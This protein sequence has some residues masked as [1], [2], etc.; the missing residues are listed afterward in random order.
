[1]TLMQLEIQIIAILVSLACVIPGIFLVLKKQAMMSD[2]I[3]HSILLGI[4]IAFIFTKDLLSPFLV[5]GAAL[6][7]LLVVF[8]VQI[9]KK[10]GLLKEDTSIGLVFPLFFS[11][12]VVIISLKFAN[13]HLDVDAVLLGEIAFAPL[14]RMKIFGI[15]IGAKSIYTTGLNLII[16]ITFLLVFFKELKI[17]TFDPGLSY[18]L[19]FS[20]VLLNYL[21]MGDVSFTAVASFDAVG[22]VLVVALMIA[23][24]ATAYLITDDL[25]K[26]ILWSFVFGTAIAL[27]G[28]WIAR[29]LD[30][31]IAGTMAAV[32]GLLFIEVF[33]QAPKKG[34]IS[35]IKNRKKLKLKFYATMMIVHISHHLGSQEYNEECAAGKIFSHLGW[36]KAYTTKI[37]KILIQNNY[38]EKKDDIL[39]LTEKGRNFAEISMIDG[40]IDRQVLNNEI[41]TV[42]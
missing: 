21:L 22:S 12:A 5:V 32:A 27:S 24:P 36:E 35:K 6:S 7:G 29:I 34:L 33:I 25:G 8:L 4:V 37:I 14:D 30:V 15:D 1:M 16:N 41:I 11:I 17:T 9:I 26:T 2:A 38:L 13:V 31:N 18:S 28:Y 42:S 3:S 19:G 39:Y 20:P 23:P 10:T 40:K